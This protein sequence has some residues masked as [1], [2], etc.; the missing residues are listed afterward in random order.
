MGL[1]PAALDTTDDAVRPVDAWPA[2][3]T[4]APKAPRAPRTNGTT[5]VTQPRR[6]AEA[7]MRTLVAAFGARVAFDLTVQRSG[8]LPNFPVRRPRPFDTERTGPC[9]PIGSHPPT[10]EEIQG[11]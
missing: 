11:E 7:A 6:R 10:I 9:I 3:C 1:A 4:S 5:A 2:C 8:S